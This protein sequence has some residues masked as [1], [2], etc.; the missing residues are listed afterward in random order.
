MYVDSVC[1]DVGYDE[2][3]WAA[4]YEI[5]FDDDVIIS[6]YFSGEYKTPLKVIYMSL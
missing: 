5:K 4:W 1:A 2:A 3:E 6:Q